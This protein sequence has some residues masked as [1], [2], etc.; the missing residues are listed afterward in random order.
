MV[1]E[2]WR[3]E[4]DFPVG[5]SLLFALRIFAGLLVLQPDVGMTIVIVMTWAL[6]IFLAGMPWRWS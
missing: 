2:S 6:Q 3:E 1:I 5:S 4:R